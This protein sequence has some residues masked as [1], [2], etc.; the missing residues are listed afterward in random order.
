MTNRF[1]LCALAAGFLFA[2]HAGPVESAPIIPTLSG[3]TQQAGPI[4]E[5]A[6][7]C[8]PRRCVWVPG[9]RGPIP[10]YARAWGAPTFPHCHWKRGLLGKW[11]YKCDDDWD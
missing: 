1:V 2:S 9:Y 6:W 11:K 4:Q 7:Q 5:A 8:G 10:D 3:A